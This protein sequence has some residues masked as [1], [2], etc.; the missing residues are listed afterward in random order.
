MNEHIKY[1]WYGTRK[2]TFLYSIGIKMIF[3][4]LLYLSHF[5]ILMNDMYYKF[6]KNVK[7]N[8]SVKLRATVKVFQI[9][10]FTQ[11]NNIECIRS[12]FL[13]V[14]S[15]HYKLKYDFININDNLNAFTLNNY[16]NTKDII[17]YIHG[18]GFIS[19][20]FA[21]SRGFINQLTKK[22]DNLI[23]YPNYRLV[24]ENDIVHQVDD[25]IETINYV[26]K[27]YSVN[28]SDITL[29]A[30]S[31]GGNIAL[32]TL[33][34]LKEQ[35]I[36]PK[37]CILLSPVTDLTC[38][39]KSFI[40]NEKSC[41]ISSSIVKYCM[42]VARKSYEANDPKISSLYGSFNGLCPL[43]FL[44][45]NHELFTYDTINVVE[46]AKKENVNVNLELIDN[47]PHTYP[48]FY[49]LFPEAVEGVNKIV[50]WIKE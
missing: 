15:T 43:Y 36:Q 21:S 47:V 16:G 6:I 27:T 11:T 26:I 37:K 1:L 46:K 18:G 42:N 25:I 20:D 40:E 45:S 29:M 41:I 48:L 12:P 19:G 44:S 39:S 35:N 7:T 3:Y 13:G 24:P 50:E 33:Q 14:F 8:E 34:K 9:T 49:F 30:D 5:S 17:I 28:L 10:K 32:L 31:A 4:S 2:P 38:S 23:I 22:I